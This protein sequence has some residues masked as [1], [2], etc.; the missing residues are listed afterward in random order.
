[1]IGEGKTQNKR[2]K[3]DESNGQGN[4]PTLIKCC[5]MFRSADIEAVN[6]ALPDFCGFIVNFP[7]SHR[8]VT[9]EQARDLLS[10]LDERI[11]A[12][13]VF[14]NEPAE[15]VAEIAAACHFDAVQLHGS[16][17][18]RYLDELRGHL[19]AQGYARHNR[20]RNRKPEGSHCGDVHRGVRPNGGSGCPEGHPHASAPTSRHSDI[21]TFTI[22]AFKVRTAADLER[23]RTSSADYVLLDNGQG[24][25]RA[26]DWSLLA[27]FERPYFL[28]GGLTPETIPKAVRQLHPY[29]I[30]ISSG[31]ETDRLKDA[32]KIMEAVN[33]V[34][35]TT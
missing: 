16:E 35:R 12:V 11:T 28:A 23:A 25:G 6:A 10:R 21:G 15:R 4:A 22:Q 33:T 7:R 34:R 9:P 30:D 26:F 32:K 14:V 31:I 29:A 27:G 18:E 8:S 17:D 3:G 24:T 2:E 1:M 20:L 13:G 19:G 5:G